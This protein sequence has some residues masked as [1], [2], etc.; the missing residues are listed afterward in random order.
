L[1]LV[2]ATKGIEGLIEARQVATLMFRTI[3]LALATVATITTMTV[4]A[5]VFGTAAATYAIGRATL[6][7][8]TQRRRDG[9]PTTWAVLSA[10]RKRLPQLAAS[11]VVMRTRRTISTR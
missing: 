3:I 4:A 11:S 5:A 1:E 9:L 8:T 10:D 2:A 7:T 6:T